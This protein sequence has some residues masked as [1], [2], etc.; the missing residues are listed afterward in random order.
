[1]Q[2]LRL[3]HRVVEH[4]EQRRR[5]ATKSRIKRRPSRGAGRRRSRRHAGAS[6]KSSP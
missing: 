6:P 3:C 5:S 2:F 1:L 4:W